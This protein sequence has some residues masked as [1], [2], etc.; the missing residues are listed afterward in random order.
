MKINKIVITKIYFFS[1][2]EKFDFHTYEFIKKKNDR[3]ISIRKIYFFEKREYFK[4]NLK[5]FPIDYINFCFQWNFTTKLWN[6]N[7]FVK[8]LRFLAEKFR[9]YFIYDN[10]FRFYYI[11]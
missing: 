1:T 10:Q 4:T 5:E 6:L 3:F 2:P 11:F 9:I 7:L 8:R